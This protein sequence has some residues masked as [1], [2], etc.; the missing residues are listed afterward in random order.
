ME[1]FFD[2]GI[3]AQEGQLQHSLSTL[4]IGPDGKVAAFWGDNE[5]TAQQALDAV[6]KAAS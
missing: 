6:K 4:V 1:Q 3:T 2:L 5:W